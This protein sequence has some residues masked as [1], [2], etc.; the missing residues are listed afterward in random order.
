MKKFR[1]RGGK[2]RKGFNSYGANGLSSNG[3]NKSREYRKYEEEEKVSEEKN[4]YE[5]LTSLSGKVFR[6]DPFEDL[7]DKLDHAVKFLGWSVDL[8]TIMP[9]SLLSMFL[10]FIVALPFMF[11]PMHGVFKLLVILLPIVTFVYITFY[12]VI[13]ARRK[14]INASGDMILAILYIVIYMRSSPNMEGAIR[15][16]ASNLKGEISKDFS[17]MLWDIEVGN[18]TNVKQALEDYKDIWRPYNKEF[19]ESLNIIETALQEGSPERQKNLFSEAINSLLN[20]TQ[21]RMKEYSRGLKNPVMFIQ[22]MGVLLPVLLMILFPLISAF[23]GGANLGYY[24]FAGYNIVLPLVVFVVMQQVLL[25]RPPTTSTKLIESADM[26]KKGRLPVKMGKKVFNVPVIVPAI[27]IFVVMGAWPLNYYL[28]VLFGSETLVHNP[29]TVEIIRSLMF[30][31]SVA[32]SLGFYLITGHYVREKKKKKISEIESEFPQALFVL[33]DA[34]SRGSPVEIA[35]DDAIN[36]TSGMEIKNMFQK[37]SNNI[38]SLSMTFESAIFDSKVGALR[39]YPSYLIR[40]VMR[41]IRESSGKG[42]AIVST[43]M[44]TISSYLKR[45]SE[46]QRKIEDLMADTISTMAFIS[47]AL[48][49]I[50][51]GIAVGM[52]MVITEAFSVIADTF[53]DIGDT[54]AGGGGAVDGVGGGGMMDP[55]EIFSFQDALPPEIIQIVVGFYFIQLAFILGMFYTKLS[56]GNNEDKMKIVIGRILLTGSLLYVITVLVLTTLFGGIISQLGGV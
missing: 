21:H 4:W 5:K 49:P 37:I 32:F 47:Y 6:A 41:A 51:S 20:S 38:K 31:L 19:V 39:D 12:P 24:L 53:G 16:V 10:V 14:V 18:Y 15:F 42:T 44:K 2:G 28:N 34:L 56:E 50:I 52:G 9:A 17:R 43:T 3:S 29:S 35:I 8:R 40:S 26:P 55:A 46:T 27:L 33:G 13:S 23:M 25:T 48:A 1:N 22:G 36:N 30:P 54:A 7:E 45:M 11:V